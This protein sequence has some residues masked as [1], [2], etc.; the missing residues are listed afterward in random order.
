MLIERYPLEAEL[1]DASCR[2]A[3][4]RRFDELG[5]TPADMGLYTFLLTSNDF[6]TSLEIRDASSQVVA[7]N[8][9]SSPATKNARVVALLPALPVT[10]VASAARPSALGKYRISYEAASGLTGCEEWFAVRGVVANRDFSAKPCD[11]PGDPYGDRYKIFMKAG[12]SVS[13][14]VIDL[15]Y[16]VWTV[17]LF[18]A[19]GSPLVDGSAA[20]PYEMFLKFTAPKDGF[21]TIR[22][23]STDAYSEYRLSIQ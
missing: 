15:G 1:S 19:S 18:D 7:Y 6:D 11:S 4:G 14:A 5:A 21:Y 16:S 17:G 22:V 8:D 12:S 2:Y 10:P 3:D 20:G 23:N 9:D 13:I